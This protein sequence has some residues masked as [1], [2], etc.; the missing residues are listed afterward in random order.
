MPGD[1]FDRTF[2][3]IFGIAVYIVAIVAIVAG[4]L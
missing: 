2:A 4:G 1:T 3:T